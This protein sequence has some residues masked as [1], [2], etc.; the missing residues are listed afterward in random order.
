MSDMS[1][2]TN[3]L[4]RQKNAF[5]SELLR[6]VSAATEDFPTVRCWSSHKLRSLLGSLRSSLLDQRV[7][8]SSFPR[9]D[10]ILAWLSDAG[11][12][13]PLPVEP[14][15]TAKA[16]DTFYLVEVGSSPQSTVS[17]FELLQAFQPQGIVSFFS[18]LSFHSLT[19]QTP[20]F[21]H[22]VALTP[23]PPAIPREPAAPEIEI[24]SVPSASAA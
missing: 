14:G 19:T 4:E 21:H 8:T 23:R 17:P 5:Q 9:T 13:H 7:V 2:A 18:A 22:S 10:G 3:S 12:V 15:V 16:E 1:P 11:L 6:R 20:P 24:A